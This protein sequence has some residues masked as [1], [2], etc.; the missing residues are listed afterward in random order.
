MIVIDNA[1]S[2]K[3]SRLTTSSVKAGPSSMANVIKSLCAV[4]VKSS[5]LKEK[6]A[7]QIQKES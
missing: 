7:D 4:M 3:E 5:N 6:E 1:T 2:E